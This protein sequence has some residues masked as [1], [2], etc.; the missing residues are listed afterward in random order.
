MSANLK[1]LAQLVFACALVLSL[2]AL[3]RAQG[4]R[5]RVLEHVTYPD[6]PVEIVAV[7]VKGVL[8]AP[9]AKFYGDADWL[10]GLTVTVKNVFDKPVARLTVLL[11]VQY[12]ERNGIPVNAGV[13][14]SYGARTLPPG[15]SYPPGFVK[16]KTLQPGET[17]DFVLS[18][19]D[20]DDL[21]AQLARHHAATDI[22]RMNIRVYQV[23]FE[24]DPDSYWQT[25]N[26]LMRDPDN[27]DHWIPVPRLPPS[28]RNTRKAKRSQAQHAIKQQSYDLPR[29][30]KFRN[31]HTKIRTSE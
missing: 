2:S 6:P 27:P 17:L 10:S 5:E 11:G 28:S 12:G 31:A 26:I 30:P 7:K 29:T 13:Y 24:G 8:V 23:H 1:G 21:R 4:G 3:G 25:G 9:N 19:K 15:Q 18:D 14:I 22:T 20:R 16:P